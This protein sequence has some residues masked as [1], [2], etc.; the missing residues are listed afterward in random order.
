MGR[1]PFQCRLPVSDFRPCLESKCFRRVLRQLA[2]SP[3]AKTPPNTPTVRTNLTSFD[4]RQCAPSIAQFPSRSIP[5][6]ELVEIEHR[7]LGGQIGSRRAFR[8]FP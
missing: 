1:D 8:H 6:L 2:F 5:A 7:N 3:V 4:A